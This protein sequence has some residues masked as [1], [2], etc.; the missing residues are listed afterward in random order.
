[1][2]VN[3]LGSYKAQKIKAINTDKLSDLIDWMIFASGT[4]SR[5]IKSLTDNLITELKRQSIVII[6]AEGKDHAKWSLI[7]LGDVVVHIMQDE[8]REYYQLEKLWDIAKEQET[9]SS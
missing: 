8:T 1:M 3:T 9:V 5:Q 7:D 4:S 6:G 2:V